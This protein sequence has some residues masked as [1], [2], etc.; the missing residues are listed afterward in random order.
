MYVIC[1]LQ[2]VNIIFR[3]LILAKILILTRITSSMKWP[4]QGRKRSWVQVQ[5]GSKFQ[6]LEEA[7]EILGE[8]FGI[9]RSDVEE[10]IRMRLEESPVYDWEFDL[11]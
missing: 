4:H 6:E 3:Y 9:R 7:K 2:I 1:T 10:M 8:V 11:N 5:R